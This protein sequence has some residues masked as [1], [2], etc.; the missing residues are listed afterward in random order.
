MEWG[1]DTTANGNLG[2]HSSAAADDEDEVRMGC[3][4]VVLLNNCVH[5]PSPLHH[6]HF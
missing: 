4:I 3:S 1:R 6:S 5:F 2:K